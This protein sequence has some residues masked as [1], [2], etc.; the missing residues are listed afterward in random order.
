M[1]ST[2]FFVLFCFVSSHFRNESQFLTLYNLDW[3]QVF[4]CAFIYLYQ[5]L[6]AYHHLPHTQKKNCCEKLSFSSSRCDFCHQD[7]F[8]PRE[9]AFAKERDPLHLKYGGFVSLLENALAS[10]FR[11]QILQAHK[12]IPM[13]NRIKKHSILQN[14]AFHFPGHC[15]STTSRFPQR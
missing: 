10:V 2:S 5:H 7:M 14:I 4:L 6:F 3:E 11:N 8:S 13:S 9:L 12:I 1:F 15:Y